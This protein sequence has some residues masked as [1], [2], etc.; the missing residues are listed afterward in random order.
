MCFKLH[1]QEK[2]KAYVKSD[3]NGRKP[4][5]F[6]PL[7]FVF[8][9][10]NDKVYASGIFLDWSVFIAYRLLTGHSICFRDCNLQIE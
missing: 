10:Y 4:H 6:L 9:L 2:D 8:K 3:S 7:F 5:D 1:M